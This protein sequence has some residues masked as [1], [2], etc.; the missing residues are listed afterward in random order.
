MDN[1]S[2]G[3]PRSSRCAAKSESYL[4]LKISQRLGG[5]ELTTSQWS[6]SSGIGGRDQLE[7]VVAIVWDAHHGLARSTVI[8]YAAAVL[9]FSPGRRSM[10]HCV[11]AWC[12]EAVRNRGLES[13]SGDLSQDSDSAQDQG[14]IC[15]EQLVGMVE[16]PER[17]SVIG[18]DKIDRSGA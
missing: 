6:R 3:I 17:L 8:C 2:V 18:F 12:V 4:Q 14:G 15:A 5:S 11:P 1:L 16:H 10:D 13:H 9:V 7:S